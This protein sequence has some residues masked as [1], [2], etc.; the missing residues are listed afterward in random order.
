MHHRFEFTHLLAVGIYTHG[1][2][3]THTF[4]DACRVCIYAE[5]MVK[6]CEL[7]LFSRL[8]TFFTGIQRQTQN[9]AID[10]R[11]RKLGS[12]PIL[13]PEVAKY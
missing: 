2:E 11:I 4:N 6:T 8:S 3:I 7:E 10:G 1:H 13:G 9:G 5:R 12:P